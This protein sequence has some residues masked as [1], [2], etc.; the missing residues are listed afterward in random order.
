MRG[1]EVKPVPD[2]E[3][4]MDAGAV[5]DASPAP[6]DDDAGS[7]DDGGT[8]PLFEGLTCPEQ[9]D[10]AP[11]GLPDD[12][13]C[14][15]LYTDVRAKRISPEVRQYAPA[16][17]LWSDGSGKQRW[18]HLPP[19]T[20]IDATTPGEW[21]FPI[22]TKFFKEF[23][24]H[25]RRIETR[26]FQKVREDRWVRAT[27]EWNR[28]ETRAVRSAGG[29][30]PGVRLNGVDYHIPTERECDLC[31][32]GREDRILGFEAISLG[33]PAAQGVTLRT[34]IEDDLIA[35]EPTRTEL[36]VGD[37]GTGVGAPVLAWLHINCGV[38]CHNDNQNSEAYSSGLRM[39][40]YPDELDGRPSRQFDAVQTTVGVATKT[41]RFG[42]N[43]KRITPGAPESSL[44]YRF[45]SSR[46]SEKDQ[47]PPI[48][49]KVVSVDDVLLIREWIEAM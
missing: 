26:L 49:S 1:H 44:L 40:L 41:K 38:S 14:I 10:R 20:R 16:V 32:G 34:L 22:G 2:R 46:G 9:I 11:D 29:D 24:V 8:G 23:R 25:G 48:A 35:P 21:V 43:Q 17:P 47:M 13:A 33:L 12:V 30:R 7:D 5:R 37:D 15:G 19:G 27:Y 31:H 3:P 4:A 18:I 45:V 39:K 28:S 36:R 6:D 42:E